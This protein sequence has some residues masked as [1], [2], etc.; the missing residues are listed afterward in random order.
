MFFTCFRSCFWH[1]FCLPFSSFCSCTTLWFFFFGWVVKVSHRSVW[2]DRC[3]WFFR[4]HWNTVCILWKKKKIEK[5]KGCPITTDILWKKVSPNLSLYIIPPTHSIYQKTFYCKTV[6]S[7]GPN[8]AEMIFGR[9]KIFKFVQMNLILLVKE[10]VV[11]RG[12]LQKLFFTRCRLWS[13]RYYRGYWLESLSA[14]PVGCIDFGTIS[15]LYELICV[16]VT[17]LLAPKI[18]GEKKNLVRV[19]N[20]H[21]LLTC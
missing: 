16:V 12:F 5:W 10:L 4:C 3:N 20:L 2:R 13:D 19:Y 15:L 17:P 7:M 1:W 14:Y 6:H 9:E 21:Q 8:F 11:F 18:S